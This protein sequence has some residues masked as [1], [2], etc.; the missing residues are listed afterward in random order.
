MSS[1]S[2]PPVPD[3]IPISAL[4]KRSPS[5]NN[6]NRDLRNC[7]PCSSIRSEVMGEQRPRRRA[8]NQPA[9][10]LIDSAGSRGSSAAPQTPHSRKVRSERHR[11]SD[12]RRDHRKPA[13]TRSN[14]CKNLKPREELLNSTTSPTFP[15]NPRVNPIFVWVRQ[16]DTRIVDVK[17]EDYDKRNR[18]L[19]T[20]TAQGWRAIP[21]TETLV[22]SLKGAA[23]DENTHHHHRTKKSRRGKV[24]RRSTGVQVSSDIEQE[25]TEPADTE[26]EQK[27]Q[28]EGEH[29][30]NEKHAPNS[31]TWI[32]A[33]NVNIESFLPS[34]TIKVKRSTSPRPSPE[35]D[36]NVN[37]AVSDSAQTPPILKCSVD[38]ICDVSPLDNLL[39]VAELEFN[40]QIQSGEWNKTTQ[41]EIVANEDAIASYEDTDEDKEFM[42]N[43]EQLNEL[44]ESEEGKLEMP[45]DFDPDEHKTDECDYNED[46]E[47]NIA[48]DDILSR[49]EQSLR[50]PECNEVNNCDSSFANKIT[51]EVANEDYTSDTENL[52]SV[53][54]LEDY[55]KE[56]DA[57]TEEIKIDF[58]LS[59]ANT[60]DNALVESSTKDFEEPTDLSMKLDDA[61]A[62]ANDCNV[63]EEPTD[64]SVMKSPASPRPP[65]QNSE[66]IQSPQPSGIPAV[67]PSPDLV[68]TTV[69]VNSKPK[70]VFLE[71]LLTNSSKKVALNS[72]VTISR[73]R[74]PLDLGKC[75]KSAS[76]TVTCSE[77]ANSSPD[78]EPPTKKIKAVDITLKNLLVADIQKTHTETKVEEKNFSVE[79]P[80]LLELLKS[81]SEPDPL[82]QLKQ[83]L[84]DPS[85]DI[86]DPMLVPKD[87]FSSILTC[88]GTEIPR[89]LRE[90][91]ELRLPEAL[92]YPHIMQ[93][94]NMLVL[95]IH[96]LE[97]ILSNKSAQDQDENS[98]L[99]SER[100]R[101]KISKKNERTNDIISESLNM[102]KRKG[103]ENVSK[104]KMSA[105]FQ[106]KGFNE[107]AND[108]DAATQAAFNQMAWLPY[109]N[110]LEAM[111]LTNSSDIMKM[112]TNSMHSSPFY[113]NQMP[114]FSQLLA[115]NRPSMPSMGFPMQ[116]T[117]MNYGNPWEMNM[118]QEAIAQANMLRNKSSFE[119]ISNEHIFK[120]YLE[121]INHQSKKN[122]GPSNQQNQRSHSSGRHQGYHN[123]FYKNDPGYQN[124]YMA[125]Y[126]NKTAKQ[127][128]PQ[129]QFGTGM[130]KKSFMGQRQQAGGFLQ[131]QGNSFQHQNVDNNQN[132]TGMYGHQSEAERHQSLQNSNQ[133]QFVQ[134]Q[135]STQRKEAS[136]TQKPKLSCKSFANI[137]HQKS[138]CQDHQKDK[139]SHTGGDSSSSKQPTSG[140]IDLSGSTT[141]GSKLKVKQH[142]IDPA[143]TP[144]LLKQHDDVPEVGS[145]TASIEEMQDAHKHLWHPLF[146]NQKGYNSP[147]N[148][149]TVTATGE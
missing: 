148:W 86:P 127:S 34:H 88:P 111:S 21:R 91:P 105:E 126:Q 75:R 138:A 107:L 13:R 144:K 50:S 74:E 41:R 82:T 32:S 118:W 122:A 49:L 100:D 45:T 146:G 8:A 72:E 68:S 142:L 47:N 76:P 40:Q 143:N 101:E 30:P 44:I 42:K 2:L 135:M 104:S 96:H 147:W 85:V 60:D 134:K 119:N 55:L 1:G 108:I 115:G 125:A 38:K 87:L 73:Q 43:L 83:L 24:R 5:N 63:P 130:Y 22:P 131:K 145:T 110:H 56:T 57:D 27:Q 17:C 97:S 103:N 46:D 93:D 99:N 106:T 121:K 81:E 128:M 59:D 95:N 137:T 141:S 84:S 54:D 64:L 136:T 69:S 6:S 4:C 94:P 53:P 16:E 9:V 29:E 109:L 89:L 58:Q 26:P 133:E 62:A 14:C 61:A 92:A 20:K 35:R 102:P 48:M 52:K 77:E 15:T 37:S 79:T 90:R 132:F 36:S 12:R 18:I 129:T 51:D 117:P 123:H 23:K 149:T 140:P 120:N 11:K 124:P 3:L 80:R 67:P 65:S 28:A 113:M 70:S 71:S 114:D 39:A 116:Q 78:M 31:P 10:E 112:L 66:A 139:I 19:L 25:E 33:D 7:A 98:R